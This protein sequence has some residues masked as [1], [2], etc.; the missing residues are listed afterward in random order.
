MICLRKTAESLLK[1]IYT[2]LPF[3]GEKGYISLDVGSSPMKIVEV[4]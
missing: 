4:E 2:I 1:P 3:G